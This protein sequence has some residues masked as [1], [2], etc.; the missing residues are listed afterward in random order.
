MVKAITE[1]VE[2]CVDTLY[3]SSHSNPKDGHYFFL[4]E[5]TI[6]NKSDFTI[7]L[8]RRH[9]YIYDSNDEM[10]EV[11]GEGVVGET[12]VLEPGERYT[13]NSGCNLTSEIGKMHGTYTMKRIVDDT[14][15]EVKIPEFI[16]V[17]PGK[18]N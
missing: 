11:E 10:R 17:T 3:L 13:Y 9:W 15:F 7:Q 5:I 6:E 1:G 14:L 4:Y 12:P 2:I 18:L 16:L 8:L